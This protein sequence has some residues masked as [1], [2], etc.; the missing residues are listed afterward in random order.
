MLRLTFALLF[1]FHTTVFAQVAPA[2]QPTPEELAFARLPADIQQMLVGQSP[3][4]ALQTVQQTNQHLI[5]LGV[6]YPSPEQFRTTLRALL[7]AP[8]STYTSASAGATTF[9]PLSPLVAPPPPPLAR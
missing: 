2:P 9:P 8:Y 5:A 4:Q 1:A 6:P 7:N 3:A